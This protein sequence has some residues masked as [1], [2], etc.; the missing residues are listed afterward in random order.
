MCDYSCNVLRYPITNKMPRHQQQY[1]W[2]AEDSEGKN[3]N[4][5]EYGKHHDIHGSTMN[6]GQIVK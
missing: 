4:Q 6:L 2:S 5:I 1:Y 3:K